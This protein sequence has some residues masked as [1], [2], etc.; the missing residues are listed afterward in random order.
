MHLA[1]YTYCIRI[2]HGNGLPV[3]CLVAA[4]PQPPGRAQALKAAKTNLIYLYSYLGRGESSQ[5]IV[6]MAVDKTQ[7]AINVLKKNGVRTFG[8]EI[9]GL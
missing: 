3:N 5:A 8:R 2:L 6:I 1:D 9:Y 7:E 4:S